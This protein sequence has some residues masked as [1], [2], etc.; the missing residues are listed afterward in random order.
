MFLQETHS[1]KKV[2]NLWTSQWGSG[3]GSIHFSHGTSNSTGV[4]I[5]FREG[6]DVKMEATFTDN[7][8]MLLILK[9]K[10]QDNPVILVNY[11][12]LMR[13]EPKCEFCQRLILFQIKL[14]WSPIQP[15]YGEGRL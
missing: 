7:G 11:H 4:L 14:S 1:T 8:G 5:A 9:A 12:D 3:K 2:E 10:I 15:L 13:R 6:L